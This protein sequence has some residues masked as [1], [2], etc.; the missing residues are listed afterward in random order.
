MI[1]SVDVAVTIVMSENMPLLSD[2]IRCKSIAVFD[3][4]NR[5]ECLYFLQCHSFNLK[6]DCAHYSLNSSG[7]I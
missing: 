7:F 2:E 1:G 5:R 4:S 3:L 6:L